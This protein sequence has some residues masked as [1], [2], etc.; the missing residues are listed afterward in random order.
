MPDIGGKAGEGRGR[1]E[2]D[3]RYR[4]RKGLEFSARRLADRARGSGA[5]RRL[6]GWPSRLYYRRIFSGADRSAYVRHGNLA[7]ARGLACGRHSAVPL[8]MGGAARRDSHRHCARRRACGVFHAE[9][10]AAR[11]GGIC[12]HDFIAVRDG[13]R[14]CAPRAS[15][16]ARHDA[17]RASN[18][19]VWN[20]CRH[21]QAALHLRLG[22]VPERAR[23]SRARAGIRISGL[24]GRTR[25]VRNP[26]KCGGR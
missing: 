9:L 26:P 11:P 10:S 23:Y 22:S 1:D 3:I 18:F 21:R 8:D 5:S 17:D 13:A 4:G 16:R 24:R 15:A 6:C 20:R 2:F 25:C 12:E 19:H 7:R 14:L